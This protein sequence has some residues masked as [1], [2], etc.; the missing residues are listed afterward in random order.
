GRF[1]LQRDLDRRGGA[2]AQKP[3][4]RRGT[5][6]QCG[7]K[8]HV[9]AVIERGLN[10]DEE[11]FGRSARRRL[12]ARKDNLRGV[13]QVFEEERLSAGRADRVALKQNLAWVVE[14]GMG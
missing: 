14:P 10:R 5:A 2:A 13:A 9:A 6:L 3:A 12:V 4:E 7:Q 11:S 1:T 8:C